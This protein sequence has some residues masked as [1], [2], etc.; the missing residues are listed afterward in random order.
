MN[1]IEKKI[2]ELESPIDGLENQIDE[3]ENQIKKLIKDSK[4]AE[5][6]QWFRSLL[7]Q[8]EELGNKID[9]LMKHEEMQKWFQSLLNGIQI[10]IDNYP[11]SLFYKKDGNVFF[12]LYQGSKGTYFYCDYDLVW[13]IFKEK[14][15]L[16]YD[17]TQEFIRMMIEQY[18]KMS[19]VLPLVYHRR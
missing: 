19:N 14:Y 9:K 10:E 2:K 12:E 15:K 3:L 4:H 1:T 13:N 8:I 18:L 11:G 7:N 5:M 16:N 6:E 17:E